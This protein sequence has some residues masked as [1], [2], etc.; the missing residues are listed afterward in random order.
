MD[1]TN[2]CIH[3]CSNV[4]SPTLDVGLF[5]SLILL[6]HICKT[7]SRYMFLLKMQRKLIK[8]KRFIAS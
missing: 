1:I 4:S 5:I 2:Y 3:I 7:F 6:S 8:F